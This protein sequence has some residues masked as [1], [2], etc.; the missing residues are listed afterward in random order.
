[1]LLFR[2]VV[3]CLHYKRHNSSGETLKTY[4][5]VTQVSKR[6]PVYKAG[7]L[8][9]KTVMFSCS[10]FFHQYPH[11][12]IKWIFPGFSLKINKFDGFKSYFDFLQ[13]LQSK[14]VNICY[15]S[16]IWTIIF[17]SKYI[18]YFKKGKGSQ[19]QSLYPMKNKCMINV[20][21]LKL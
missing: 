16:I 4:E 8:I 6:S 19:I 13:N 21:G 18:K 2:I 10:D 3:C 9:S 15:S 12:I 11:R 17:S 5:D 20:K 7:Q 14:M 1:M